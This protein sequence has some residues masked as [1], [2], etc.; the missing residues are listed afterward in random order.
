M[1]AGQVVQEATKGKIGRRF[2]SMS[3]IRGERCVLSLKP[4]RAIRKVDWR[5]AEVAAG[6]CWVIWNRAGGWMT[7]YLN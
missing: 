5:V 1:H 7:R 4:C 6:E 3:G 2:G